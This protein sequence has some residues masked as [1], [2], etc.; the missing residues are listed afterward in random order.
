MHASR[1]VLMILVG[2]LLLA[3]LPVMATGLGSGTG[4]GDHGTGGPSAVTSVFRVENMGCG[5]CLAAIGQQLLAVDPRLVAYGDAGGGMVFVDHPPA[6]SGQR[7]AE[8]ITAMGY[9]A[10]YAGRGRRLADT[11]GDAS[12]AGG[13]GSRSCAASAD[14]WRQL[15]RRFIG[16]DR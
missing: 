11:R 8:R 1:N 2:W 13:C 14:T 3:P 12:N 5:S 15:Y 16:D 10:R 4:K 9:P 7:L 6:F